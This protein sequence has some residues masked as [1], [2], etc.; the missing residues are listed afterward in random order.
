MQPRNCVDTEVSQPL[1]KERRGGKV[2][3]RERER[4]REKESEIGE[5]ERKRESEKRAEICE[6]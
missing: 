2:R 4:D 1:L 3:K 6:D 5:R